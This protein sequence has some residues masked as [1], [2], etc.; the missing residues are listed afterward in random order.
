LASDLSTLLNG[1]NWLDAATAGGAGLLASV[2]GAAAPPVAF[3]IGFTLGFVSDIISQEYNHPF[4]IPSIPHAACI[5]GTSGAFTA[6]SVLKIKVGG[7]TL[8]DWLGGARL[9][10]AYNTGTG[11]GQ[12]VV[13]NGVH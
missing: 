5:G 7:K 4:T 13:C 1:W 12:N 11:T 8:A 6:F 9:S 2:F 3:G 10:A